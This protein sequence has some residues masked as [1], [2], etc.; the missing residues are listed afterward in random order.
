MAVSTAAELDRAIASNLSYTIRINF[1]SEEL[2][3]NE[4][5]TSDEI[6]MVE[7]AVSRFAPYIPAFT[8]SS[9]RSVCTFGVYFSSIV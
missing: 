5:C 6:K 3:G 1:N 7:E 8:L 9:Y 2:C 4:S